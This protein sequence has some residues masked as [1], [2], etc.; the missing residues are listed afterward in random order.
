MTGHL[1]RLLGGAALLYGARRYYRNW[2]TTKQECAITLPGDELT[3]GPSVRSTEGVWVDAPPAVIW[4]VLIRRLFD[5]SAAPGDTVTLAPPGWLG[6]RTV[7]LSVVEAVEGDRL[8]LHGAPPHFPWDAVWSIH[9]LL[10]RQDR[11]RVLVRTRARLRH[12]GEVLLVESAG[13]VVAMATR[14][15]LLDVK[16]QAENR[17]PALPATNGQLRTGAR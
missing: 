12:P 17:L 4:P 16:H 14:S 7:E 11:C 13:P 6:P 5:G 1:I 10:R 8:V 15:L 2:G 9:L 3:G